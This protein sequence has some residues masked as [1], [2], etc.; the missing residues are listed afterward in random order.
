M[1]EIANLS[2]ICY[3]LNMIILQAFYLMLPAYFANMAPVIATRIFGK[4]F[5]WPL[6]FNLK[7]KGR[8][9]FGKNKTWR[10]L[11]AGV[12]VGILAVYL[13]AYLYNYNFFKNLS[14][15]DYSQ[16]DLF[17]LGLLLG[18]GVILGDAAKSFVKRQMAIKPGEKWF[19]Y[20][21]LD[22]LGALVLLSLFYQPPVLVFFI[23]LIISPLLPILANW[24]GYKLKI[25]PVS[26]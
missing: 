8:E 20:D 5:N 14:L 2:L 12:L 13:Q 21:Q 6:D 23:I 10:G 22:F 9:I 11:L 16:I 19:P 26:W 15:L 3:N 17:L 18:F 24:F 25:K 4:N 7:I 1:S